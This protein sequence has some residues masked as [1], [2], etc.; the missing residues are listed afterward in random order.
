MVFNSESGQLVSSEGEA[1][2]TNVV[3][4]LRVLG[5]SGLQLMLAK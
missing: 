2:E 4:E 3:G 1:A 5:T